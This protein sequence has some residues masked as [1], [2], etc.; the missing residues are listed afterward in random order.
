[1]PALQASFLEHGA[2]QCGICTPGLLVAATALLD[3]NPHPDEA[4]VQDALGGVLCRCTGY[5]KI[6]AA[7]MGAS[8]RD[9]RDIGDGEA[10]APP[11][12]LPSV[13]RGAAISSRGEISSVTDNIEATSVTI[14]CSLCTGA[15]SALACTLT[16]TTRRALVNGVP[17]GVA[18]GPDGRPFAVVAC[19]V[20]G[21][22]IVEMDILA[23]PERLRHLDL[24]VVVD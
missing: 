8:A 10:E 16:G 15:P 7:V 6:I 4:A 3:R 13:E 19:T 22:R 17:G 24:A 23:D 20:R 5:R 11:S 14:S 1:M 18:W 21:G 9:R 12:G 2:A